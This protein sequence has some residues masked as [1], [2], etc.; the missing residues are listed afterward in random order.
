MNFVAFMNSV[1][2]RIKFTMEVEEDSPS[3]MCLLTG[4]GM[5]P[6]GERFSIRSPLLTYLK[7]RSHNHLSHCAVLSTLVHRACIISDSHNLP[8]KMEY[9][10]RTFLQN[11]Y[12]EQEIHQ[13]LYRR[14]G[15][16]ATME[17]NWKSIT[18]IAVL[19]IESL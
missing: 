1:Q 9:L 5:S 13:V 8:G 12:K 11:G 15:G 10:W 2:E 18:L 7:Y 19:P 4:K 3:W 16:K 6:W 14:M 17:V